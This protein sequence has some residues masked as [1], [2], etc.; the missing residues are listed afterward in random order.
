MA[1]GSVTDPPSALAA[2]HCGSMGRIANGE[3]TD[4]GVIDSLAEEALLIAH[5]ST[6][7][8]PD[9]ICRIEGVV[10]AHIYPRTGIIF[11]DFSTLPTVAEQPFPSFW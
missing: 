2:N 11:H 9:R 1:G 7:V 6:T 5:V 3:F 4:A 10:R 8:C